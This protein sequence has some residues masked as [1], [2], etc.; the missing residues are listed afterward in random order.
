MS[1]LDCGKIS[2]KV[3]A[4]SHML[5]EF[6]SE[7]KIANIIGQNCFHLTIQSTEGLVPC[8]MADRLFYA[9]MSRCAP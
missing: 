7:C 3:M 4:A 9:D 6:T 2:D 1:H 5:A 8:Q